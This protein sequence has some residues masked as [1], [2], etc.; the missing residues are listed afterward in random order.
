MI[1][2]INSN[3]SRPDYSVS[4]GEIVDMPSA[5]AKRCIGMTDAAGRP[6]ATLVTDPRERAKAKRLVTNS[7]V[8]AAVDADGWQA[9]GN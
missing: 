7:E 9:E 2:R 3:I 5:E 4:A 6:A 8:S 1:V